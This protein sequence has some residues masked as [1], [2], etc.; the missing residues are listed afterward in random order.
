MLNDLQ[1]TFMSIASYFNMKS[2]NNPA[3]SFV[4]YAI[5][6]IYLNNSAVKGIISFNE[7][8]IISPQR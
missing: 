3:A 5:C 6:I 7:Y 4:G 8:S 1:G 2:D